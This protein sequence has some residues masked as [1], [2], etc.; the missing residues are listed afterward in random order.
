[1]THFHRDEAD[2]ITASG[3][4]SSSNFRWNGDDGLAEFDLT[5]DQIDAMMANGQ[6][7]DI[8]GPPWIELPPGPTD[9]RFSDNRVSMPCERERR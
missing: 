8:V 2:N 7:V 6:P 4:G 1:M 5:E 3:T 9:L